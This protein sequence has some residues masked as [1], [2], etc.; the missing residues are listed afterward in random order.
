MSFFCGHLDHQSEQCLK[1]KV[2]CVPGRRGCVLRGKV[3]F[4]EDPDQRVARRDPVRKRTSLSGKTKLVGLALTLFSGALHLHAQTELDALLVTETP[5]WSLSADAFSAKF[6]PLGFRW[7]SE[8]R[9]T[10]RAGDERYKLW[11]LPVHEALVR[12]GPSGPRHMA[13]SIFNRGDAGDLDKAAFTGLLAQAYAQATTWAGG[14][15]PTPVSEQMNLDGIRRQGVEWLHPPT[16]LRLLWSYSTK[17]AQGSF[18]YRAE[19]IRLEGVSAVTTIPGGTAK[20]AVLSASGLRSRVKKGAAGDVVMDSVPMVDQG[21]KGYCVVAA[22]ERVLRYYAVEV[23]QHELAQL[24]ASS[25]AE[26]T[27]PRMMVEGLK[28]VGT[29]LG[30]RIKVLEDFDFDDFLKMVDRYNSSAKRAK[31]PQLTYGHLVDVGA[32]YDAMDAA[33]LREV[34]LKQQGDFGRFKSDITGNVERGF[35]LLWS[36]HLGK[37]PETPALPQGGGGHMRLI[38]GYNPATG[39]VLYS[40]S[41]GQGHELK[42]MK[43]EEAWTITGG[44]YLVEPRNLA[45]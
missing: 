15:R 27:D 42:R 30:L 31:L 6:A 28:R 39:E 43:W 21:Q 25:A 38:I 17:D 12:F 13:L 10:A 9:D 16:R 41:W 3:T 32:L 33:L 26:G 1:L 40:D 23:D 11:G 2:E 22:A 4:L 18:A 8:A 14:A 45:L 37:V 34:R 20:P 44:L 29:R 36:V 24:S 5:V 35:P 19:Y 7:T